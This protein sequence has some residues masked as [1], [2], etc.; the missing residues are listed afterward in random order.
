M[1]G[2]LKLQYD[3]SSEFIHFLAPIHVVLYIQTIDCIDQQPACKSLPSQAG[4]LISS[5]AALC[6]LRHLAK[7]FRSTSI[8][9]RCF[10]L[11]KHEAPLFIRA[12]P[13]IL[14]DIS[15]PNDPRSYRSI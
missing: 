1:L 5:G 15:F 14:D 3:R 4:T 10:E 7:M 13:E 9:V 11:T 8:V 12:L 6:Y 2:E